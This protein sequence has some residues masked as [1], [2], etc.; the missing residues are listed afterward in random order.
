MVTFF[1]ACAGNCRRDAV[2][3]VEVVLVPRIISV[4]FS[5]RGELGRKTTALTWYFSRPTILTNNAGKSVDE[6]IVWKIK[7]PGT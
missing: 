3:V 7:D 2:T 4:D 6:L 5:K 1:Y